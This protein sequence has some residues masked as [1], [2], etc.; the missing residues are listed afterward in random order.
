MSVGIEEIYAFSGRPCGWIEV[1]CGSMFS[2]KTEELIRRLVRAQI[3]KQRVEIFKPVIDDRYGKDYIVSHSKQRIPS[4]SV[5]KAEEILKYA[6]EAQVFG[7]D[8]GQF[9]DM[10][11]V[12]VAKQLAAAGR[13][14]IIA[15][16]DKDYRGVP[17]E[18][19]PQLLAEAEYIT[20]THAICMK[21]GNPAN[22]TQRLT[23]S[24]ERVLVGA[25]NI[26]EARCRRCFEAPTV[27]NPVE[28]E[29]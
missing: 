19:I 18:P 16:L 14:I 11:L 2:G 20:K 4:R 13:R 1:I 27:E 22:F 7:I 24:S 29:R 3:A 6:G 17:F 9:F 25:K 12:D 10:S 8:E 21:C 15:G 5:K 26:Y 23:Q 28:K